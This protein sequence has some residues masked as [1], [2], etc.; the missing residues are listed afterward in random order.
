MPFWK[1]RPAADVEIP[2]FGRDRAAAGDVQQETSKMTKS[3]R[4]KWGLSVVATACLAACSGDDNTPADSGPAPLTVPKVTSCAS[5]DK[6]EE[7]L[8]G[9]VPAALRASGFKGFNCNL[10]LV[11]QS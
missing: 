9:Q 4:W 6:A 1:T 10:T 5:G 3:Q 2:L 11:G 8:Q 7:A